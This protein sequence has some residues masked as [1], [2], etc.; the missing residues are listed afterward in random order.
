[1][2]SFILIFIALSNSPPCAFANATGDIQYRNNDFKCKIVQVQQLSADGFL[3]DFDIPSQS[4]VGMDFVVDRK[5][6]KIIGD[7]FLPNYDAD[8]QPKII[9]K[10]LDGNAFTVLTSRRSEVNYLRI[11]E[12]VSKDEKPFFYT[13]TGHVISG[14]CKYIFTASPNPAFKRDANLPP[15]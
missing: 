12:Y 3:K 10:G 8:Y 15:D 9:G 4:I 2:K 5:S 6:G 11:N 14:I 7:R 13:K 1:M